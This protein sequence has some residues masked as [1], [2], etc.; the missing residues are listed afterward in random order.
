[1]SITRDQITPY[2]SRQL[3]DDEVAQLIETHIDPEPHGFSIARARI[4]G[5][6]VT[7]ATLIQE[8]GGVD[9][10]IQAAADDYDLSSEQVLAAVFFYWENQTVIDAAI[11][12]RNSWFDV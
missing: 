8:L 2:I 11:T 4:R 9:G 12:V 5:T 7:V 3:K 6:G 1:M 10:D